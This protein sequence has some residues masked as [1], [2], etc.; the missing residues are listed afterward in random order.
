MQTNRKSYYFLKKV[1]AACVLANFLGLLTNSLFSQGL[2]LNELEYFEKPG[3]NVLVYNNQYNG[4]FFDEK[5]A[6]IEII[7]HGVRT[8]TG[9][10]VRL[11]N[12]PEQWDLVPSVGERKVD[13]TNKNISVELS[14]KEYNFSSKISVTAKDNGVEINVY[15]DKPLPKELEGYAG[16]NLEFLPSTYFETIYL[17]DGKPGNFPRYP[18]GNTKIETINKKIPQFGGHTTFDDR[19]RGEF[20]VPFPMATGKTIIL[21][22]EDPERMIKVQAVDADLML[23]DGRNLAQNG[24]FVVRSLLP[25]NKIGKVLTW[26]LEPNSIPNWI[27]KPVV[28]FS[29]VGYLPAQEKIAV[30]ELDKNDTPLKTASI[31]RVTEEGKSIE[32]FKGDVK[33]WGKYLRYNYAKFDFTSIKEPGAYYIQYGDQKTNIF[34]IGQNV[35]DNVWHPT[36]DVWFPVQMDHMQVNEAY[37]IWHGASYLDDCLQAPVNHQHFDGYK[38]GPTTETRYKSLEHI[39]GMAVGG[40]FDAGDFDIQTG[41]HNSVISSFVDTWEHFKVDRDETY[42]DQKTRYVDIHRPD[43]KPDILQQIEH[44]TLN[45]VAQVENIGHPVRGIIVPNLHQYHHLGD[46]STETDN[47]PYNPNLKPYETDGKSSG[48]MDDRWA[49][50]NRSSFLD[51]Q[52]AAALAGA[53]RVLKGYNNELAE[54]SLAYAK[55]LLEEADEAS[56]KPNDKEEPWMKMMSRGADI[57]AVLQLFITT[58]E[59]KYADRFQE[60]I[61]PLLELMTAKPGSGSGFFGGFGGRGAINPALLA[62]SYMDTS[63]KIKLKDYIV[64]YKESIDGYEKENPYGVPISTGSWG[65]GSNVIN[66]AI[67]NYYAHK[68]Y[69]DIIGKE[70]VFKGL[71][72]VFGCHPYS[73]ISFVNAVGTR[74]KKVAYGNNRADFTTI[75]GGVVPGLILLKPDFLENKDDWPFL[76]G[77]NEC[78]IDGGAWYIFLANAVNDISRQ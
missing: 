48:T 43:G 73:N 74:S 70:Y 71:N 44:G 3:V 18:A 58:K 7:H 25:A 76:W 31:F 9:G 6:G 49:F 2:K 66:W 1:T 17:M 77:E 68:A 47:L 57:N 33:V 50:T 10:A 61:W 45:L 16:F 14:Y 54:K 62:I 19:S 27:R 30:I 34:A 40:W 23:F 60:K 26:Y 20:I 8:S 53:S 41:S 15:L 38:Q 67:I 4:M 11:Q 35:Y 55:K 32:K 69:P 46:A 36:M 24:W 42:I 63:Y 56:K 51:Y 12:T 13:T 64:K 65:G 28:G 37:R 78:V 39:P 52:T 59:K 22:P 72:F 5:T 29:Q 21:A 75:A